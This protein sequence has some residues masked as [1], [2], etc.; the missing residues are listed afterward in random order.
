VSSKVECGE[1]DVSDTQFPEYFVSLHSGAYFRHN[2]VLGCWMKCGLE[3]GDT[4]VLQHVQQRLL[5]VN[6][7]TIRRLSDMTMQTP[8]QHQVSQDKQSSAVS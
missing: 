8:K 1:F 4:V 6:Q 5:D 7:H 3:D 2:Y